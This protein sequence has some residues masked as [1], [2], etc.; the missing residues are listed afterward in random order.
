MGYNVAMMKLLSA[1]ENFGYRLRELIWNYPDYLWGGD[2]SLL[3]KFQRLYS[4]TRP[5]SHFISAAVL[6]VFVVLFALYS[7]QIIVSASESQRL[8]EGIVIGVDDKGQLQKLSKVSPLIPTSIQLEKDLSELIYEPL[9]RVEQDGSVSNVLAESVTH[10]HEGSEYEFTLR[11]NVYWHDG[12]KFSVQDVIRSFEIVS[13]LS[14]ANANNSYVQAV[15]QMAW[16]QTG[17]RSI[18][19]CTTTQDLQNS[20]RPDEKNLKCSG[21]KGEK[22]ILANFLE[23]ISIK[24][25]PAHLSDDL[26]ALTIDKP[27]PLINR[28]PVGTGP[29]KFQGANENDILLTRNDDYYATKPKIA[30]I[31]FK[32][33]KDEDA[34]V[35]ALQNGEIHAL[36][37]TST[38]FLREMNQYPQIIENKS[39]VLSN[40]YWAIYFNLRKDLNGKSLGPDFFQDVTV[41]RAISSAIDRN[42]VLD[43]LLGVGAEAK[44]PIYSG[45]EFFNTTSQWYT[46]NVNQ[47][48]Q[49][50]T[51]AGWVM[52]P[53]KNVRRK[54]DEYLSFKLSYADNYDRNKVVDSIRQDL[55]LVGVELVPDP[56]PLKDLTTNVVTPKLFDALLFGVSTFTDPDRFELFHSEEKLNLSSYVGSDETVKISGN[57]TVKVPRV[58][59]LLEQ[60]RSF[61]P[62]LAKATRID[63]YDK[64]QD[65]IASDAPVVFLYHPQFVYLTNNRV[66]GVNMNNVGSLEQRFRNI[67]DWSIRE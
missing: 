60:G 45:S 66:S 47:A 62:L 29:Y 52:D 6:T 23:L 20:L 26:N 55:Q 4:V 28:F 35:T 11:D 67:Q 42:R 65:L 30:N 40:E 64:V 18:R 13:E 49:L 5:L 7:K 36:A 10:I 12:Y 33:F 8:V 1:I 56:Q 54:G 50:L 31:D 41:R 3:A 51:N 27:E 24:I 21:V 25:L 16:E 14:G 59:K 61:D 19:I 58:D 22:P 15:K 37:T 39:P 46:Y 48:N 44:G 57:S 34:A 9:I 2:S 32:L 38:E 63:T 53:A 17:D 43:V